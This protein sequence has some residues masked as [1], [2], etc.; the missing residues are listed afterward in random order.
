MFASK[1][2]IRTFTQKTNSNRLYLMNGRAVKLLARVP[3][4][5]AVSLGFGEVQKICFCYKD[6]KVHEG[7]CW[8]A[9]PS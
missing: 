6:T 4:R 5:E 3:V 9:N 8:L 1:L 2:N 7:G